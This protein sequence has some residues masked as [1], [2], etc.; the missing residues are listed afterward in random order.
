MKPGRFIAIKTK[1]TIFVVCCAAFCS[2]LLTACQTPTKTKVASVSTQEQVLS[3]VQY[4]IAEENFNL[5]VKCI[6][7]G[8]IDLTDKSEDFSQLEKVLLVRLTLVGN[9]FQKNYTQ[10]P[11][12]V[13]D[14]LLKQDIDTKNL[15]RK[16][17]CDAI[18]TGD[19]YRFSSKS[20]VAASSTEVGLDLEIRNVE[21]EVIWRGRHLAASRDGS[22]PFSPLSLLSGIFLARANASDEVALQMVDS[23]VRRLV[24]TLPI[25]RQ[26]PTYFAKTEKAVKELFTPVNKI[27]LQAEKTASELLDQGKYRAAIQA[28]KLD[29]QSDI[30]TYQNLLIIGDA[31]RHLNE[32]HAAIESYLLAVA[33][34]GGQSAGYEK[35]SL[36]YLNLRRIDLAKAS[37]SKAISIN[38]QSSN[39]RYQLAIINESQ[40]ANK[41]AAKLYFQAGELAIREKNK[42]AIYSSLTALERMSNSEYGY[43]FYEALLDRAEVFQKQELNAGASARS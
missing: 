25:Q 8:D 35:L 15:L 2:P 22:L 17:N 7:V 23:V 26:A 20:F 38:P 6:L 12:S 13:A 37:L 41:E 42:E 28:A 4:T 14:N 3:E 19:I 10:V 21:D 39:V 36:G 31:H 29:L 34:D 30:N 27:E 1:T 11:L 40:N 16:T 5:E 32:F 24:S 18:I 33:D 9:L 43:A